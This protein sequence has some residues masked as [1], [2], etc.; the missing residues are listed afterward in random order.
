MQ[1]FVS[2]RAPSTAQ[3]RSAADLDGLL[4]P[5]Q[6]EKL[7]AGSY[8]PILVLKELRRTLSLAAQDL[9][10]GG[11]LMQMFDAQLNNLAT[12]WA[13][14]SASPARRFR[15]HMACCYTGPSTPTASF[16]RSACSMRSAQ[17]PLISVLVAY[18][19]F[20]LEAI[21]RNRRA[22]RRSTN[23]LALNAIS[24]N[25]ERSVLELCELPLPAELKADS[26]YRLD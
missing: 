26:K 25:I 21:A 13:D 9:P 3:Q 10:H 1:A 15:I 19:L 8:R 11:Q 2:L 7:A 17:A 16:C 12:Q 6:V 5:E 23:S 14:A 22:L 4:P 18:T 24:R 20:A